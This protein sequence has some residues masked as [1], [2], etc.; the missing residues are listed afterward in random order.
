ME[1]QINEDDLIRHIKEFDFWQLYKSDEFF[2]RSIYFDQKGNFRVELETKIT[3]QGTSL[4][5]ALSAYNWFKF[6]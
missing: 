2:K 4:N 3:Y 1:S 5:D 6:H